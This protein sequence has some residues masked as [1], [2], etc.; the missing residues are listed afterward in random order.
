MDAP[1]LPV[2]GGSYVW[3]LSGRA[4]SCLLPAG[5]THGGSCGDANSCLLP[6]D[7]RWCDNDGRRCCMGCL[8]LS[9]CPPGVSGF[10]GVGSRTRDAGRGSF[11]HEYAHS[12]GNTRS[13]IRLWLTWARIMSLLKVVDGFG[14]E[15]PENNLLLDSSHRHKC[16][17]SFLKA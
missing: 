17:A 10:Q 14:F 6:L 8:C 1:S 15:N 13:L 9:S 3:R 5:A 16:D 7:Q 4:K 11:I 2:I 12:G